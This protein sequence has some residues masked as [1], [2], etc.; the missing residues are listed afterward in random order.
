MERKPSHPRPHRAAPAAP[1]SPKT[2]VF[3][4]TTGKWSAHSQSGARNPR[5][6]EATPNRHSSQPTSLIPAQVLLRPVSERRRGGLTPK[7]AQGCPENDPRW[8]ENLSHPRPHRAA[9]AAPISPKTCV[10]GCTT[11]K[12]SAHSQSGARNPRGNEA[13]SN[14]HSSQPTSLIPAQVL[15]RPVSER[16][17]GGLTPKPAQ[18]CPENDPRWRENLSHPR[19]HRAAPAAPISPKTCVFGCTT[20]KWSAHS[21]SGAQNPR[22]N[23]AT[24]NRHS[25]QLTSL[26][27]AQVLLRP[28]S[29]RRRGGLP[30]KTAQGCPEK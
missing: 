6:N 12:W 27:P 14:R 4:C 22:G 5:G 2:C 25:S 23:E 28:V 26:I 17:R 10:F 19:P 3:G 30:P 29:E 9:P 20:G 24:P 21:Q 8:R 16:R 11:G 1:I 7:P 13:T 18:G 15:L